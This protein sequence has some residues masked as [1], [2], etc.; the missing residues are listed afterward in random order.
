LAVLAFPPPARAEQKQF[1]DTAIGYLNGDAEGGTM[2]TSVRETM[3][4]DPRSIAPADPIVE[5]ARLM[6]DE[7]I[8]SLP[9]TDEG[10]LVGML[11]DRDIAVRVIAEGMSPE[12]TTVGEVFSRDPV[13]AE[14][15]QDLD[16]ALHLMAQHQVRRLPVVEKDRLVGILAQADIALE[17]KEKKTG[18]LV[19]SISQP[20]GT[21][22]H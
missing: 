4:A 19:E 10:K 20:S 8:G 21:E 1:L 13:A 9:V 7:D 15:D 2:A 6:R 12:S 16:E 11:T 5:A 14:P 17:E 22:R 18:E 3:T